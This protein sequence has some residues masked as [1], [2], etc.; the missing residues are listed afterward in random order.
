MINY[1]TIFI[2]G[3]LAINLIIG[4]MAIKTMK[5]AFNQIEK[6]QADIFKAYK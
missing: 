4:L 5:K 2:I 6:R 1:K 3:V